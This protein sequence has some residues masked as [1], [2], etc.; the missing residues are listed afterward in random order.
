[1][2]LTDDGTFTWTVDT[3]GKTHELTGTWSLANDVLTL[4]QSGEG[5][6]LVGRV[7]WQADDRW[8]FR[9]IGTGAEDPGLAFT[10]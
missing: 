6:A 8:D 2:N 3:K 4:A 9:V 10:R 5:G 7:T 1:M